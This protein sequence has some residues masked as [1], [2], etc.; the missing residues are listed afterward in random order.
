MSG[1]APP[2]AGDRSEVS[3]TAVSG[4]VHIGSAARSGQA[5][6]VAPRVLGLF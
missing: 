1:L 6:G 3:I 5:K 2:R 4:P